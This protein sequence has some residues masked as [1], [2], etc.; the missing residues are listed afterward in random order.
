MAMAFANSPRTSLRLGAIDSRTGLALPVADPAVPT[1]PRSPPSGAAG[2]SVT[3]VSTNH[4]LRVT[5]KLQGFV[6]TRHSSPDFARNFM[7]Q[8]QR[9]SMILRHV[10]HHGFVT[11]GEL[12]VQFAVTPQTVRRDVTRLCDQGLARRHHGGV[13]PPVES[14]NLA[15]ARRQVLHLDA[16][17]RI[18][19]VVAESVAAGST[20]FLGIGT[21]PEQIALA[22]QDHNGLMVV[23]NNLGVALALSDCS[24]A[25]VHIAG[26]RLR[27]HNR[28]FLDPQSHEVIDAYRMDLAIC[29]V[30]GIDGDGTLLDFD[31][32]EV[33]ARQRMAANAR[34]RIL[35]ADHSKFGRDAPV[36]GGRLDDVDLLVTD[37][38]PPP[39]I[40]QLLRSSGVGL[41]VAGSEDGH[42]DKVTGPL[43][44]A[45]AAGIES[46]SWRQDRSTGGTVR[47]MRQT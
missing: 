32:E 15:F 42:L 38:E 7:Q 6:R 4:N 21:T 19:R 34:R 29:G 39:A 20:L 23:T 45:D 33:A 24:G 13:G 12:A 9:Q 27:A 37:Q 3:E 5:E 28:D 26:E 25:E 17:K 36:R 35:V 43:P 44:A 31:R 2:Q 41:E 11:V 1:G 30:G 16:K 8:S 14:E 18:A 40:V 22:L 47:W 10:H 46:H